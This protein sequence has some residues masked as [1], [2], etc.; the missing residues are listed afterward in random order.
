MWQEAGKEGELGYG[1]LGDDFMNPAAKLTFTG[2]E[3]GSGGE[4]SYDMLCIS[5]ENTGDTYL[6]FCEDQYRLD[7]L[8][9][10]IW[11]T[12]YFNP[13][14]E[15]LAAQLE[16]GKSWDLRF[17]VPSGVLTYEGSFRFSLRDVGYCYFKIPFD[18]IEGE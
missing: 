7:Y 2:I 15:L 9:A 3:F 1:L 11:Y 6:S 5:V 14:H 8:H 10:D 12:V 17:R 18:I 13:L 4:G 16:G